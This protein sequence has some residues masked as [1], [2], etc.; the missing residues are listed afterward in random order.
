MAQNSRTPAGQGEGSGNGV[1]SQADIFQ[2][3][4]HHREIQTKRVLSRFRFSPETAAQVASLAFAIAEKEA[5]L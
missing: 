4:P 2:I 1:A 5:R 3:A